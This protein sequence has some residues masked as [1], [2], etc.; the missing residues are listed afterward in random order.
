MFTPKLVVL[1]EH[2]DD[3][4]NMRRITFLST[5]VTLGAKL[6]VTYPNSQEILPV[7]QL[8]AN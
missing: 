5:D 4:P 3:F 2:P 6:N 1:D 7:I 8:S